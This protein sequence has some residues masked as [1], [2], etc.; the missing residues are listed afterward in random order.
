MATAAKKLPK[1]R[2]IV[3]Q[4]W[5]SYRLHYKKYWTYIGPLFLGFIAA[6]IL[7]ATG[8]ETMMVLGSI[9]Y[10]ASAIYSIWMTIVLTRLVS[11]GITGKKTLDEAK[12]KNKVWS[13]VLPWVGVSIVTGLVI[14]AGT[15]AFIIPGII[16]A[17]MYFTSQYDVIVA[18]KG[19]H[20]SISNSI[21]ITKG[22]KM[23]LFWTILWASIIVLLIYVVIAGVIG[24]ALSA[25]LAG[26]GNH[27]LGVN[28]GTLVAET[29]TIP[30]FLGIS[31]ALYHELKK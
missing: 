23:N 24:G 1:S 3:S 14:L 17:M 4:A 15:F 11:Q 2:E 13:R 28:I 26:V 20:E 19:V 7:V 29:L 6:E 16:L 25:L 22:K 31:L 8:N 9:L 5:S 18:N 30:M 21:K 27:E 10:A 12:A